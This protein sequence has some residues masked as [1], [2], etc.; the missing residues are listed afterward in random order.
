MIDTQNVPIQEM[1]PVDP[2]TTPS[3][4]GHRHKRSFAISGDFD[5]LKQ[6]AS[7]PP[8]PCSSP[9]VDVTLTKP[10]R[11]SERRTST[12]DVDLISESEFAALSPSRVSNQVSSLSPRFFISEEPKFS[13]P[14]HGVPDAIINLDDALKTKPKSFKS[15]RRSESAPADLAVLMNPK[16]VTRD[17]LM[18]EEEDD[19]DVVSTSD[20]DS[21]GGKKEVQLMG[22]MSPLRPSSP[23]PIPEAQNSSLNGSPIQSRDTASNIPNSKFNSLKINRQ[24]QRY[25]H[26]T[27]K[28]PTNTTSTIQPQSLK[29]Q[30]SFS[31]LSSAVVKTPLSVAHTPSKQTSTPS[32]PVSPSFDSAHHN[33]NKLHDDR[34][35]IS[36]VRSHKT[37]SIN[38]ISRNNT[39]STNFKYKSKIYDVPQGSNCVSV[40]SRDDRTLSKRDMLFQN[41][42]DV[43]DAE[44]TNNLDLATSEEEATL[45]I[46]KELLCGEPGD[47][48]DLSSLSSPN[49]DFI[50]NFKNLTADAGSS[51]IPQF[52]DCDVEAFPGAND[53]QETRSVSDSAIVLDRTR[54][55]KRK[56]KSRLNV[57]FMN[58]FAKNNNNN[59]KST[60]D[61]A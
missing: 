16:T 58:F 25:Y 56:K 12:A 59:E 30:A 13:S 27:K 40:S 18:I 52:S 32:T 34:R 19:T 50:H 61:K 15:H 17:S 26:Y 28:L 39:P 11:S 45:P 47:V 29:E 10:S 2:T 21:I 43:A 20:H 31:S 4:R 23:S 3:Q 55:D 38:D 49:K 35:Q 53:G 7:L 60:N 24:K 36:P 54:K 6:P 46:S 51:I 44:K 9:S 33:G 1:L 8:L 5:F 14:F 41:D 37:Q 42:P 22:L 48:V 57:F